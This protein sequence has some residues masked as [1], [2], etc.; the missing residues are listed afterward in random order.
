MPRFCIEWVVLVALDS[1]ERVCND[2]FV[3]LNASADICLCGAVTSIFF[4]VQK[5]QYAKLTD[6][7]RGNTPSTLLQRRDA[8][9]KSRRINKQLQETRRFS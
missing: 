9:Y 7:L 6:I 2:P 1:M 4:D 8:S 5:L 3:V